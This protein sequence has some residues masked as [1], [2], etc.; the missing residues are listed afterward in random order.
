MGKLALGGKVLD[1]PTDLQAPCDFR[2]GVTRGGIRSLETGPDC[3]VAWLESELSKLGIA[4]A[5]ASQS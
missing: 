3:D 4:R 5:P 1:L 2:A